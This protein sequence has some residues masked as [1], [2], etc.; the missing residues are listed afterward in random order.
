[1]KRLVVPTAVSVLATVAAAWY[2]TDRSSRMAE[3]AEYERKLG[4]QAQVVDIVERHVIEGKYIDRDTINRLISTI[5]KKKE[6]KS[7]IDARHVLGLAEFNILHSRYLSAE[8]RESYRQA[9]AQTYSKVNS[10]LNPTEKS[11]PWSESLFALR[12]SIID[13][14]TEKSLGHLEQLENILAREPLDGAPKAAGLWGALGTLF[15]NPIFMI[16]FIGAYT[17]TLL[18]LDPK[19]ALKSL[20][21][22]LKRSTTSDS[23]IVNHD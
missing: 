21:N 7:R 12:A 3:L 9:L 10:E 18:L 15:R 2:Q 19:M 17:A 14:E 13:G 5:S 4:A 20:Q 11:A 8:Q 1:M 16:V 23:E 22:W 6:L